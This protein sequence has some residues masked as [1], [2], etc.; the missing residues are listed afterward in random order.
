MKTL[1]KYEFYKLWKRKV[2]PLSLLVMVLFLTLHSHYN[3]TS[4]Y[5]QFTTKAEQIR[6]PLNGIIDYQFKKKVDDLKKQTIKENT[7]E[8]Y[9]IKMI[10]DE[11]YQASVYYETFYMIHDAITSMPSS[12][13]KN[14]YLSVSNPKDVQYHTQGASWANTIYYL[15]LYSY[16]CIFFSIII[17]ISTIF[18]HDR[19]VQV[20]DLQATCKEARHNG[21]KAK[22]LC[23][24]M[25]AT[26]L[27]LIFLFIPLLMMLYY[28]GSEGL[29]ATLSLYY[30]YNNSGYSLNSSTM[31]C[32]L[33]ILSFFGI[34]TFTS[35]VLF[36]TRKLPSMLKAGLAS[37][38]LFAIP[39]IVNDIPILSILTSLTPS[40]TTRLLSGIEQV[41]GIQIGPVALLDYE[42]IILWN[43]F[44]FILMNILICKSYKKGGYSHVR[45]V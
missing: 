38:S 10:F 45:T 8:D 33:F 2:I 28:H 17:V 44:L 15:D 21:I 32:L 4:S 43:I 18:S 29:S 30:P 37:L 41:H 27:W 1:L 34:M 9:E 39:I 40:Y 25:T 20:E 5:W 11:P 14:R 31:L 22:L 3:T 23:S 6:T 12:P 19:E 36:I 16:Y 42:L 7:L 26:C 35:L 13:L 24:Y